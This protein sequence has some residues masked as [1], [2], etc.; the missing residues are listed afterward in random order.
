MNSPYN[1]YKCEARQPGKAPFE[2]STP[3]G[4]TARAMCDAHGWEFIRLYQPGGD[5]DRPAGAP[6]KGDPALSRAQLRCLAIEAGKTYQM[7]AALD[8]ADDLKADAW[9]HA[10][11]LSLTG[12]A[13]LSQCQNSHYLKLLRHFKKLRGEQ[14]TGPALSGPQSGEGGDTLE[15]REQ[16]VSLLAMELGSHARRVE[17]PMSAVE[18]KLSAHAMTKGGVIRESYLLALARGKNPGATLTDNNCLITLPVSRLEQLHSTLRN[19]IAAREG[20]GTTKG[21]NKGQK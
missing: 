19:R 12:R 21:R 1:L 14:P 8:L 2:F 13:G 3:D 20:R 5:S 15:R 4:D 16:V 17:I 11:V 10:Q 6:A 18:E 9:R 7:L